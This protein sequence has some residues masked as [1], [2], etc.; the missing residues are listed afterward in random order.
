MP[1]ILMNT[2]SKYTKPTTI[3]IK[4][5]IPTTGMTTDITIIGTLELLSET[6]T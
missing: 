5:G 2:L 3:P 4:T 6:A 1:N